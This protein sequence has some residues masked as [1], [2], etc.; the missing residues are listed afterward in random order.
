M[1]RQGALARLVVRARADRPS[2]TSGGPRRCGRPT[3]T[4]T[5]IGGG[6]RPDGAASSG[7]RSCAPRWPGRRSAPTRTG[8]PSASPGSRARRRSSRSGRRPTPS[9]RRSATASTT[10]CRPP[11][12]RW[13]RASWRA[14]ARRCC[15]PSPRS[16]RCEVDRRLPDRRR[17]RPGRAHRARAPHRVQ[18]RVRRRRRRQA[19]HRAGRRRGLRRAGGPLRQHGRDG[20]HRPAAGRALR[21]AERRVGGGA[22]PHHQLAGGR[23]ADARGTRR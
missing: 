14:A 9:S 20:H 8:S 5:I 7:C 17:D 22:D 1:R 18:R 13:P 4:P 23:G 19:G 11:A 16:T 10:R 3:T 21:A 6:G 15:T 2:S 12:P